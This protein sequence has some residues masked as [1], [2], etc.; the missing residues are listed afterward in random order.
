MVHQVS[1]LGCKINKPPLANLIRK[2]MQW[3]DIRQ[4]TNQCEAWRPGL[5]NR[6]ELRQGDQLTRNKMLFGLAAW[7][8][9][10]AGTKG[11]LQPHSHSSCTNAVLSCQ[12]QGKSISLVVLFGYSLSSCQQ[13]GRRSIWPLCLQRR[14]LD[15]LPTNEP[16]TPATVPE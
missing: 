8:L 5:G 9:D 12:I 4:L 1:V 15:I 2:G 13:T 11:Q 14:W 16:H 7:T 10:T 6:Q 3:N